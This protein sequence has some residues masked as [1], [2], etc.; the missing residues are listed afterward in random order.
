MKPS[1]ILACFLLLAGLG[2]VILY[3]SIDY[4]RETMTQVSYGTQIWMP[5]RNY[6]SD[7]GGR[8]PDTLDD[9]VAE[10]YMDKE[11]LAYLSK[12]TDPH[13]SSAWHYLGNGHKSDEPDFVLMEHTTPINYPGGKMM[14]VRIHSE[15]GGSSGPEMVRN[16]AR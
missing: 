12:S 15:W 8:F 16:G 5:C 6:A 14:V 1:Q 7:H 9:L 11:N 2:L 3:V 10:G 13:F 4:K